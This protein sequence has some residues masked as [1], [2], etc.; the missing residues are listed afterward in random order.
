MESNDAYLNPVETPKLPKF[1]QSPIFPR[2]ALDYQLENRLR[3]THLSPIQDS[4]AARRELSP[5]FCYRTDPQAFEIA[6]EELIT[7]YSSSLD[8]ISMDD[9]FC[10]EDGDGYGAWLC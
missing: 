1:E 3:A 5:T 9:E 2:A 6:L 10:G 7:S 4:Q 8:D